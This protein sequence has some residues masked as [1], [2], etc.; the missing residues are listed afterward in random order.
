[1]TEEIQHTSKMAWAKPGIETVQPG[2]H[3]VTLPLPMDALTAVNVYVLETDD[4]LLMIDGGWNVPE[5]RDQLE[6]SLGEIGFALSDIAEILVTHIHRDHYTLA[7]ALH[8]EFG[9]R[10][11]LGEAERE[12][13]VVTQRDPLTGRMSLE[14]L[15][16][17]GGDHL[18]EDWLEWMAGQAMHEQSWGDPS[19]WFRDEVVIERGGVTVRAIPTPGH[20]QGHYVFVDEARGLLFSGDHILPTITPSVGFEAVRQELALGAFLQS[21]QRIA[22]LGDL[23]LMPSHGAVGMSSRERALALIA[24]HEQRFD[25][26][27]AQVDDG[28]TAY[29]VASDLKWTRRQRSLSELEPY[30]R[31]LAVIETEYHLELLAHRGVLD[32]RLEGGVRFYYLV[33]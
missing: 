5:G 12:N 14:M 6:A 22:D 10:L 27:L 23:F 9:C 26:I 15:R 33:K 29:K 7:S 30:N 18:A 4:G 3:R 25:E 13:L 17:A 1:M 28:E 20:T 2:V 16:E 11:W 31:V 8:D 19:D 21:L 24:H 32:S